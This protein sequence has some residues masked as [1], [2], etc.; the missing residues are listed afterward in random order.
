MAIKV[1]NRHQM[2]PLVQTPAAPLC[3]SCDSGAAFTYHLLTYLLVNCAVVQLKLKKR[4][5]VVRQYLSANRLHR[6]AD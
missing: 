4:I 5:C 1:K 3:R 6:G 2:S